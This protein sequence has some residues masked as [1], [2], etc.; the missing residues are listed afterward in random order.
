MFHLH[1]KSVF[2]PHFCERVIADARQLGFQAATVNNYGEQ[3]TM[4]HIRNNE[5]LEWDN[6][7]LA[8][9][10]EAAIQG[11]AADAFPYVIEDQSFVQA[12]SHLRVYRYEP[13]Q[14]F[15]PHR[16]GHEFRNGF[17]SWV[18]VLCY[19]N[20]TAGGE[21]ILM[22]RSVR[23]PDDWITITPQVGDVLLFLH[24]FVHEGRPVVSGEKFALRTELFY[25]KLLP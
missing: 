9:Q 6:P 14:Y 15:K 12:N 19:L 18:T 23:Y 7:V 2:S 21:T 10:I 5:R 11:A 20:D 4:T 25:R 1:L 3:K 17:E 16:D 22:P 13:G 8:R 24:D